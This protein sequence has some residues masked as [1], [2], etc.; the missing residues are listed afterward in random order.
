M[1][2]SWLI[3]VCLWLSGLSFYS[4]KTD[5]DEL[6]DSIHELDNRVTSLEE[7][8]K[9]VNGNINALQVLVEAEKNK[10][11]ITK[12]EPLT[13]NNQTIGYTIY[14]SEGDPITI[15]HGK[16]GENGQDGKPGS[17]TG[18]PQIGVK[19]DKDGNYYWTIEGD[20]LTDDEGNKIRANGLDGEPGKDGQPGAAGK[21]G[22]D[23]QNGQNGTNGS[24]GRDGITPQLKIE[25]GRW[26]VSVDQGSTWTD[27][28]PATAESGDLI[29]QEVDSSNS[30]FVKFTL[31][32]GTVLELVTKYAY[33]TLKSGVDQLNT[34]ITTLRQLIT[35]LQNRDYITNVI[36]VY[37]NNQ[38][39]GYKI[40]FASGTDITIRHGEKGEQGAQGEQGIQ[41]PQG[42]QG[43]PGQNGSTPIIGVKQD[44]DN[45][46]YWTLNGE[47][48]VDSNG[49]KVRAQ[50]LDGQNGMDGQP[51]TPGSDGQNGRD[52]VTPQ[53]K[54]D[55]GYWSVSTDNG[56]S[57][58]Q[59]GKATG[60]NGQ[61][62]QDGADGESLF[63]SIDVSN[64]E[65]VQ[66]TLANGTTIKLPTYEAFVALKEQV[67]QLNQQISSLQ[68]LVEAVQQRD[69]ITGLEYVYEN[70]IEIGYKIS[71]ANRAAI[72]VRH[73][74]KGEQG[75]QGP[76]GQPGQDGSTPSIGV[77]QD[78]DN[79]YYWT[80][81]GV[82]L[83]DSNG[84][85]VRAQG[86]DGQNGMDGQ[87]GV[88]GADG[89]NGRD[90]VT[91]QLRI[92]DGYWEVSTDNGQSWTQ[93][94]KATGENGQDGQDGADGESLFSDITV[95]EDYVTLTLSGNGETIVLPTK[96]AFEQLQQQVNILNTNISAL[97]TIV[98]ALEAKTYITS[99]VAI[100]DASNQIIGY[101]VVL[102]DNTSFTIYHGKDG[103]NG[104]TPHI[105]VIDIDGIYYW[106]VDG[107]PIQDNSG[108][109]IKVTGKDGEDGIT[110]QLKI[111]DGRWYISYDYGASWRDIGK[112]TGDQGPAGPSGSGDSLF[113]EVSID[114]QSGTFIVTLA[115]DTWFGLPMYAEILFTF[116]DN[117]NSTAP[118]V[119]R[120]A[121]GKS[122]EVPFQLRITAPGM[123]IDI[124]ISVLGGSKNSID[125][126]ASGGTIHLT[127]SY[128]EKEE[129]IMVFVKTKAF[130]TWET[131]TVITD[132]DYAEVGD[133]YYSS[134]KPEGI[135]WKK[136]DGLQKGCML[137][138]LQ[139]EDRWSGSPE[140]CTWI[141]DTYGNN[142]GWTYPT[143]DQLDDC[144]TALVN[145]GWN[146]INA[147]LTALG[148]EE[149][150]Y[151]LLS[152]TFN[153][154][155]N[156]LYLIEY[157]NQQ[158]QRIDRSTEG[159]SALYPIRAIKE[160]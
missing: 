75:G 118:M 130:T 58:T 103:E 123:P 31:T 81:N 98:T 120:K 116:N 122:F 111:E 22:Q 134:Y 41:G 18:I 50:G 157:Q 126:D 79:I 149:I 37:E 28:G 128:E 90:G 20:W 124:Q 56:Q 145:A 148:Y 137:S 155:T 29:F 147:K 61:D 93:L 52:G 141:T 14:F 55:N 105:G 158:V 64:T 151:I 40:T 146:E 53:L 85:K 9:Q 6:W 119:Y 10:V 106:A 67:D 38:E 21:P 48:L 160:F 47:W 57:W 94:G 73:G 156:R 77:K 66:F 117:E 24:N 68:T 91:P 131:F 101:K 54:I 125:Y 127:A 3:V 80:L 110:P 140:S 132:Y 74:E 112:A 33:E 82:W 86:L 49:Q 44:T 138:C 23:G 39:I 102:S 13:Q 70:G 143:I 12:V 100:S 99:I 34:E 78:I 43:Q 72:V 15:Y 19:L 1:Y 83:L 139:Y 107:S 27:V 113:K 142:S 36:A 4:C 5:V 152:R 109:S 104:E 2:R 60:E 89:Q 133:I 159:V 71:F 88:P 96:H 121:P 63:E 135:V 16:D 65:Y 62:G 114:Q 26:L 144:F 108:N 136:K 84:Q 95:T 51:G 69:Y 153:A 154:E 92:Q 32:D 42:E 46:Y 97:Q 45:I 7:L 76:Q 30:N 35:A 129:Q 11:G 17:S 25:N 8:C 115:N 87:P 150:P 59:L